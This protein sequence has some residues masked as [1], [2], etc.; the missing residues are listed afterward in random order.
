MREKT[1]VREEVRG[2]Y[3]WAEDGIKLPLSER[4]T[5]VRM[6]ELFSVSLPLSPTIY[7]VAG[8]RENPGL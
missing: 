2:G 5:L 4:F 7:G 1:W 6:T 3:E 8:H